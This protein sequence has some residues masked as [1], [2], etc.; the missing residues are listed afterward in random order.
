LVV[1]VELIFRKSAAEFLTLSAEMAT[2][3]ALAAAVVSPLFLRLRVRQLPA[4]LLLGVFALGLTYLAFATLAAVR[5]M[6]AGSPQPLS[7]FSALP[8]FVAFSLPVA[9][10]ATLAVAWFCHRLFRRPASASDGHA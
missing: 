5:D 2:C 7:A 4:A 8:V 1:L 10:P 6:L 9:L 3:A